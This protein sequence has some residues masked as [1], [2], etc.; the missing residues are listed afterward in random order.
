MKKIISAFIIVLA[1]VSPLCAV[2]LCEKDSSCS[3]C[4]STS[5]VDYNS[6]SGCSGIIYYN[7]EVNR[8][9]VWGGCSSNIPPA[10]A[11]PE[12]PKILTP[13]N[14]GYAATNNKG[15]Y[16]YCQIKSINGTAVASSPRWVLVVDY[17]A[18]SYCAESCAY[19]CAYHAQYTSVFRSVLF[20]A[21]LGF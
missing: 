18:S 12:T 7:K 14:I 9:E 15:Q 20:S 2:V 16:C 5:N 10:D 13:S 11:S 1:G 3:S 21:L 19:A 6:V 8:F 17:N 4:T